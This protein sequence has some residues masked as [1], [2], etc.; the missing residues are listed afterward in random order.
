M[1]EKK[2]ASRL[3]AAIAEAISLLP[4]DN[5]VMRHKHSQRCYRIL[6]PILSPNEYTVMEVKQSRFKVFSPIRV[7]ATNERLIIAKPS[8]W[9]LRTGHN[10]FSPTRYETIPYKHI[11]SIKLDTGMLFSSVHMRMDVSTNSEGE[12]VNSI[13][14]EYAKILF[15]FLQ[16]LTESLQEY[17]KAE[18]VNGEKVPEITSQTNINY[19]SMEKARRLVKQK[20][21]KFVWLGVEPLEYVSEGLCI[22]KE[23]LIKINMDEMETY[24]KANPKMFKECIFVCYDG[25][26]ALHVSKYLMENY[27]INSYV[28]KG[29][30][31]EVVQ[32]A[33]N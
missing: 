7:I 29:G 11:V 4:Y 32:M 22:G 28:L 16:K 19:I 33:S 15:L 8:F 14:S 21:T 13:T 17:G 23:E 18:S 24:C 30:I 9:G 25:S 6:E 3:E 1:G 20:P 10:I 31:D 27:G 5:R 12:M 2:H 26:L